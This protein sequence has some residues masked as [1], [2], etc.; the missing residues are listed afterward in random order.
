M[1]SLN[2]LSLG[3]LSDSEVYANT[4]KN[5]EKNSLSKL[6]VKKIIQVDF[7]ENQYYKEQTTKKQIVLHHTVSG[8]GVDGDISWWRSTVDRV[9]TALIID[10]EGKIFQCFSSLYWGHHLGIKNSNN[11]ALNKGSIGIEIDSWGGLVKSGKNWHPAKWENGKYVPN[12]AIKP[13][14]NVVEFPN[15]Y[16]GLYGFEAYT[17]KQIESVKKLLIYL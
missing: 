13:I 16:K 8:Q 10:W 7:P 5:D 15:G 17:D 2:K 11:L 6:D 14:K 4:E 12:M 9:A 1:I 3:L